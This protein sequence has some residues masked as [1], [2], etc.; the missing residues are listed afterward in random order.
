[1]SGLSYMCMILEILSLKH[2][3]A[4]SGE[5]CYAESNPSTVTVCS[6]GTCCSGSCCEGLFCCNYTYHW[7]IAGGIVFAC[8]FLL[9]LICV[10]KK[11]VFHCCCWET[12]LQTIVLDGHGNVLRKDAVPPVFTTEHS[13]IEKYPGVDDYYILP[14]YV[15][16]NQ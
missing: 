14:G 8:L 16:R 12:R 2:A 1:M 3:S 4:S 11:C 5:L 7:T 15:S 13:K 9:C 6:A 10:A